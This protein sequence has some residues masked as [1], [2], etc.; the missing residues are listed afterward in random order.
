MVSKISTGLR[1]VHF[2]DTYFYG[3]YQ[4]NERSERNNISETPE[5]YFPH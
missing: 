5:M 3:K 4:K 1:G 2:A